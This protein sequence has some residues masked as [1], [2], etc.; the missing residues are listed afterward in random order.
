M[1]AVT[2]PSE[3]FTGQRPRF[4]AYFF[5]IPLTSI[6]MY[7]EGGHRTDNFPDAKNCDLSP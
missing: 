2:V 7:Y 5:Y 4:T 3:G 1:S 6:F